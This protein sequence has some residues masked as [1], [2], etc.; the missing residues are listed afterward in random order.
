MPWFLAVQHVAVAF[1]TVVVEGISLPTTNYGTEQMIYYDKNGKEDANHYD[2]RRLVCGIEIQKF[3]TDVLALVRGGF[4][5]GC[6]E[7]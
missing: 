2:G 3:H 6:Q 5:M 7:M 4:E 1:S